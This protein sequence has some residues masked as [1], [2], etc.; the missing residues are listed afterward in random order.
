[1]DVTHMY[2]EVTSH[3]HLPALYKTKAKIYHL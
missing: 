2:G 3:T 1:M